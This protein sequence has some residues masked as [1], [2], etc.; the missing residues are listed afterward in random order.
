MQVPFTE[1]GDKQEQ[2]QG[3]ECEEPAKRSLSWRPPD[4]KLSELG[5]SWGWQLS[6]GAPMG[7]ALLT[8][9]FQPNEQCFPSSVQ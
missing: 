4:A 6:W 5:V 9:I 7:S 2:V 8:S 3:A 1:L